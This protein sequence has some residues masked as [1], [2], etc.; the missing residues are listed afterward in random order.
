[1]LLT[2]WLVA[3]PAAGVLPLPLVFDSVRYS[4]LVSS[5]YS[6][7]LQQGRVISRQCGTSNAYS[8]LVITED[9]CP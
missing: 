2:V 4:H 8:L 7:T 3:R 9:V 1:M 5:G 6:K